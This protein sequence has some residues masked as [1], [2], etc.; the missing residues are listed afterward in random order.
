MA[1]GTPQGTQSPQELTR[2]LSQDGN[3][4]RAGS[5][6]DLFPRLVIMQRLC[7]SDAF[8]VL[9]AQAQT[10]LTPGRLECQMQSPASETAVDQ[11]LE[12]QSTFLLSHLGLSPRPVIFSPHNGQAQEASPGLIVP[13]AGNSEVALAFPA[14]LGAMGNGYVIFFSVRAAINND[15]LIDLH[16]KSLTVIREKLRLSFGGASHSDKLNEREIECLQLVG[17]GMKSEAIGER[18]T[19]SVHTVNAYLGSATTKLNAVN[20]IQAIAKAIRLGIIA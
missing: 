13:S 20:R 16:R 3:G 15:L 8:A 18:L 19:L 4:G 1:Y 2:H 10:L 17:N 11:L 5:S 6:A 9:V 7:N 12:E 14:Q